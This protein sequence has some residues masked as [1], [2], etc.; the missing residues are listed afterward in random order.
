MDDER[1]R[2][3][4]AQAEFL[5]LIDRVQ[6][7]DI[8]EFLVWVQDSFAVDKNGQ[9]QMIAAADASSVNEAVVA[10][11][12]IASNIRCEVINRLYLLIFYCISFAASYFGSIRFGELHLA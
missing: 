9:Q 5:K 7:K 1:L 2:F 12:S 8:S 10:L 6:P 3:D 11:Q 4:E